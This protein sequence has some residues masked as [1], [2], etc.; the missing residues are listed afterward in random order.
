MPKDNYDKYVD[1]ML[2][3]IADVRGISMEDIRQ[4]IEIDLAT[5]ALRLYMQCGPWRSILLFP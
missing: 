4:E 2:R 5:K 3:T 1:G